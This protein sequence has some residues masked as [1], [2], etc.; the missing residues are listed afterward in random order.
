LTKLD[1]SNNNIEQGEALHGI[2]DLCNTK[3]I[4]M[5]SNQISS[6]GDY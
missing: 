1:I 6:D 4:A 5:S 2:T 3:G